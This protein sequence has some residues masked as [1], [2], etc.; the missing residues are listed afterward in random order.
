MNELLRTIFMIFLWSSPLILVFLIFCFITLRIFTGKS[1]MNPEYPPVRG[2]LFNLIFHYNE[3][4]D[5]MTRLAEKNPTFRILTPAPSY[6]YTAEPRNV[7]HV[8]KS[9]FGKYSKGD[10][11][12]EILAELFGQGIFLADGED[13]KQQ[14]KLAG[15]EFSTRVLRDFSCSVFRTNAAKLVRFVSGLSVAGRAFDMQDLLMKC[16]LDSIFEVGFGVELNC[17]EGSSE[18]GTEFMKAFDASHA[19]IWWR[20]LD[21]LWKLRRFFRI[22]SEASLR[23][24][25]KVVDDFVHQLIRKKRKLLALKG[26]CV[27]ENINFIM[28]FFFLDC[29]ITLVAIN[30]VNAACWVLSSLIVTNN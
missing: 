1:L 30:N 14:R 20:F 4:H 28:Q 27:S 25:I 21:P 9:G 22:G 6:V 13:W 2:T 18:E 11:G 29:T 3:L 12:R 26:N 19:L 8:L 24:Q 17:V 7:E 15:L 5:Y 16:T 10:R 23:K